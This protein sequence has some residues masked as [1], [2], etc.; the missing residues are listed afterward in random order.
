MACSSRGSTWYGG[1][2]RFFNLDL[3]IGV[4][5][6]IKQIF[7]ALGH[8]VTD[9]SLSAHA[10]VLGREI[11]KV[12]VVNQHTW[13]NINR[14]MCDAFYDRYK[15]ELDQYDA[16]IVTH[17]PCFSML[18]EQ[19]N[20]PIIC[21]AS[22]R[23]EAPFSDNPP[24]WAEFNDYLR[25]KI[26]DGL[27]IP[28]ANN[29]Y[30]AAYAEYFTQRSWQVIPS[31]CDYTNA[32]YTGTRSESLYHSKFRLPRTIKNLV[33]KEDHFKRGILQRAAQKFGLRVGKQGYTW[34][35]LASFRS[36]V[37]VPYNASIMSIFETYA[38]G[39]PM[40]FPSRTFATRLYADHKH[41]GV[42]SELSYNQV[43]GLPS[44]SVIPCHSND[45][46]NYEDDQTMTRWIAKSDF[47]D[48]DNLKHVV[49]F[50]SF[51]ELEHLLQTL[52]V[53]EIHRAMVEH[54]RIR[55]ARTYSAWKAILKSLSL[56]LGLD[57]M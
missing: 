52:D 47:Y 41:Q 28:V 6:D 49:Y 12:E 29:K 48:S 15:R 20:K 50:D 42:F 9:W 18:Y 44:G 16:F 24:A 34:Q 7:H 26:D 10:R 5:G 51:E 37:F 1:Q 13:K 39:I 57:S 14:A 22:T 32:R 46:N 56:H 23:Y 2:V 40:L 8:K 25:K 45:P 17:T 33:N 19:W 36:A 3:H 38:A 35:Q 11:D 30:D 43:R 4:I 55:S 31:L 21:V 53:S 54:H 27:I